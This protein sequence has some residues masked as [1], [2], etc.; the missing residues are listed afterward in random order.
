MSHR[1]AAEIHANPYLPRIESRRKLRVGKQNVFGLQIRVRQLVVVQELH[2]VAQ[3][4]G[5]VSHVIHR[6]WLVVVFLEEVE[7][8]EAEDFEGD[9]GV[10]VVVEPIEDLHAQAEREI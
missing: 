4:V 2:S 10:A 3:L 1:Q 5:D 8:A 7:D 6:V 9:T